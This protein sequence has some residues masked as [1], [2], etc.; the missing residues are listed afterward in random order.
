MYEA[1]SMSSFFKELDPIEDL[2]CKPPRL[3]VVQSA[4]IMSFWGAAEPLAKESCP[5][6]E[7]LTAD[8]SQDDVMVKADWESK[9]ER[10]EAMHKA[11]LEV[12]KELHGALGRKDSVD[13]R[14]GAV[15]RSTPTAAKQT[16]CDLDD[17]RP[18]CRDAMGQRMMK[19]LKIGGKDKQI[20]NPCSKP[21]LV[22]VSKRAIMDSIPQ[23]CTYL[24][25]L[26]EC[27]NLLQA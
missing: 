12:E 9:G 10:D 22:S 27:L 4:N 17:Q 23:T 16:H 19:I 5:Q 13:A 8:A 25:D 20:K 6:A 3:L 24:F 2:G 7:A 14:K 21:K 15:P 26:F 11:C 18:L 1:V